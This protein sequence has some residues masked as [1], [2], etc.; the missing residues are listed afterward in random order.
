MIR[1]IS[2]DFQISAVSPI[3]VQGPEL[4]WEPPML[5]HDSNDSAWARIIQDQLFRV[6]KKRS[7]GL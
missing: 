7:F 6:G 5:R 4:P 3:R 2:D 1:T